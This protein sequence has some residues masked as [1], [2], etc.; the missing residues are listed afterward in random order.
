MATRRLRGRNIAPIAQESIKALATQ[1]YGAI[2]IEEE[3]AGTIEQAGFGV[4]SLRTIQRIVQEDARVDPS[5]AWSL[6]KADASEAAVVLP[7]LEELLQRSR[8]GAF[9]LTVAEGKLVAR[10]IMARPGLSGRLAYRLAREY[11]KCESTGT[12]TTVLDAALAFAP[13]EGEEASKRYHDWWE[14]ASKRASAALREQHYAATV[15]SRLT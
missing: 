12:P 9:L 2:Q 11:V 5:G 6:L 13:W 15:S 4:P 14:K 7:V 10:L 1:G 8:D 3:I